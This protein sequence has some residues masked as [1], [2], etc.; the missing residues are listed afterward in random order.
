MIKTI[1]IWAYLEQLSG[2]IR[3]YRLLKPPFDTLTGNIR[4]FIFN[5]GE[6]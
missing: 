5:L 6:K 4:L 3:L 2:Y 1:G